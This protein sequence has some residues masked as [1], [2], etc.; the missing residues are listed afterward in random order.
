[1][2]ID[3]VTPL[4]QARALTAVLNGDEGAVRVLDNVSF[5]LAKGE[6]VDIVGPSGSGKSTFM[7]ALARML[8]G[9]T[10]DLRLEGNQAEELSP[11]EWRSLVTLLPQKP[12]V[13]D[14][15]VRDNIELPWGFKVRAAA[16][17]PSEE[18]FREALDSLGLDGVSLDREATRLSVGQ[19]ARLAFARA[20]L[21]SPRVLLLDEAEAALDDESA[22]RLSAA[23]ERFAREGGHLEAHARPAGV[24]RVR[25]RADDGLA[26]RRLRL[27]GG[28]LEE[29]AR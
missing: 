29:V 28:R 7:R 2:H 11:Q 16:Q 24:V 15:S 22:A 18:D 17:R 9:A 4:L 3:V 12:I 27:A 20:W 26:A 6:V 8:P 21:V 1:M 5:E 19:Q 10:G 25:H 14:G 13:A 23:V